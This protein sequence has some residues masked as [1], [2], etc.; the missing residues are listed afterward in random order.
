VIS[1]RRLTPRLPR[2][3][4]G[5]GALASSAP[6]AFKKAR[7]TVCPS[8][9]PWPSGRPLRRPARR[10]GHFWGGRG[11]QRLSA[12]QDRLH[13]D[14]SAAFARSAPPSVRKISRRSPRRAQ[15]R[16]ARRRAGR[17]GW[18][19][20]P[21]G[22]GR[23]RPDRPPVRNLPGT[24]V[25]A[26]SLVAATGGAPLTVLPFDPA[27]RGADLRRRVAPSGGEGERLDV[28]VYAN[29]R[30]PATATGA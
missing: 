3:A 28:G 30:P 15:R 25:A 14:G 29:S 5:F 4:T 27:G 7:L 9:R 10:L 1:C 18:H 23:R 22:A 17:R 6:A 26:D 21:V 24:V 13:R 2:N 16:T 11:R 8:A 20:R 19:G 12:D